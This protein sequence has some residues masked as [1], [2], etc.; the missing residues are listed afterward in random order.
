MTDAD[1]IGQQ[2]LVSGF[3]AVFAVAGYPITLEFRRLSALR[4]GPILKS[5]GQTAARRLHK[6]GQS[7][8]RI[9]FF[10]PGLSSHLQAMGALAAS[11]NERG[12]QCFFVGH[13]D[14]ADDLPESMQLIA[15]DASDFS[16]SPASV[17][18][19]TRRPALPFG[20]RRTVGD[21]A[22]ITRTLTIQAPGLLRQ[23]GIDAVVTDQMEAG[24]ALVAEHLGLPFVS[25]AVAAPINREP[26]VPLPVLKWF[27]EDSEAAAKRNK[28]GERI[29]DWLTA[30]HDR[31]IAECAEDLG[32]APKTRLIDCL[33]PLAQV[34]QLTA[35]FDLPRKR[36]PRGFHYV[37]ALR[38]QAIPKGVQP[39]PD[40]PDDRPFVFASM[41][42]LQGH[43]LRLFQR[44]ARA[45][46]ALNV[47][48]MIAHC[49]GLSETQAKSLE[50]DWVV[51][52][53][54]QRDVLARAD[55]VITHA[56]LN[57]VVDA[58]KAAVP[59]LCIPLAFD[60]PG[61][62]AR[63][64][65]AGVGEV[66]PKRASHA[67]IAAAL[68]VLLKERARYRAA[69]LPLARELGAAG[70]AERAALIIEKAFAGSAQSVARAAA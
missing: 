60:Q 53:V 42:T 25:I 50:A 11:L 30:P 5:L 54:D 69:A 44:I 67:M 55:L 14:L 64:R 21:M 33:S 36:L 23:H 18:R 15:L 37:G 16:W 19:N 43:R 41:G 6:R 52:R 13:P 70:G 34:S 22:E 32:C 66:V 9:A 68:A 45:C 46:R 10:S 49:G 4:S 17:I 26:M 1:H 7:G 47:Q 56:G 39:L 48:L 3:V 59:M 65:H 51:D 28:V 57:T 63:V 12:H 24:G 58:L 8:L 61:L 20:I 2:S 40:I 62:A 31:A 38:Q 35:G 29:A 27:F